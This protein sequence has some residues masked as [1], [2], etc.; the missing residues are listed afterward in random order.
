MDSMGIESLLY[1]KPLWAA[2]ISWA[3][4]QGFK[5]ILPIVTERRFDATRLTG[6]GGMPSSHSSLVM[7][8]TASI[9]KYYGLDSALFAI[10]LIFSFVV[11]YDAAGIR[12]AAGKQA[13]ILN[14]LIEHHKLPE[15]DK[16]KE[17][18]GHTPLEVF[19]GALLGIA[20]GY[21][22]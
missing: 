3:I 1:N 20:V 11:M 17:L 15:F 5:T 4:A 16:V 2:L 22:Y 8:M 7:A 6:T 12:R 9:G 18:L 14:Y 21:L 19:V 10:S 13:E